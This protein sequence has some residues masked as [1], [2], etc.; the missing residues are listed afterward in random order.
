[1]KQNAIVI[2]ILFITLISCSTKGNSEKF[3]QQFSGRYLYNADEAI[4]AYFENTEL[5]LKW[6]GATKIKPLKIDN[7]TFYVKEMVTNQSQR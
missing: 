4:E 1:M 3:I 5:Y 6:R 2:V 7:N